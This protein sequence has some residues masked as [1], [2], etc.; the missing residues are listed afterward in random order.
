MEYSQI[1]I[2][3]LM[4]G[5]TIIFA[6]IFIPSGGMLGI[7]SI[8]TI[9]AALV[10]AWHAWGEESPTAFWSFVAV[11]F[12]A[13]PSAAAC[14][15][16]VFPSTPFGKAALLEPP[17]LADLEGH[18]EHERR[19]RELIGSTGKTVGLLTPGGVVMIDGER[20]HCES[21][22]M[23]IEAGTLVRVVNVRGNRLVVRECSDAPA[24]PAHFGDRSGNDVIEP[25]PLVVPE[26]TGETLA[27]E[28]E[29]PLDFPISQG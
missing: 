21:E 28:A 13:V 27:D 3:L 25:E 15:L 20:L 16:Y 11:T 22:G 1:A 12:V 29:P 10:C 14:A 17:N 7:M 9:L 6:E 2:T 19:L 23:L 5:L 18:T 24:D 8:A 26:E 4:V